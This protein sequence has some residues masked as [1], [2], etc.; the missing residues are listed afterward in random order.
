[1]DEI[2]ADRSPLITGLLLVL[3]LLLVAGWIFREVTGQRDSLSVFAML[4]R[5]LAAC[6][7]ASAACWRWSLSSSVA[8]WLGVAEIFSPSVGSPAHP[9]RRS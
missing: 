6:W 1:V 9:R 3:L 7:R 2:P 4:A 5:P 8:F